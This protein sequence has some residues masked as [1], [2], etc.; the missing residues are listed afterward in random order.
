MRLRVFPVL[1]IVRKSDATTRLSGGGGIV[2]SE[3]VVSGLMRLR[4]FPVLHIVRKS[5][6]TTRLSGGGGIVGAK[7]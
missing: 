5:D 1:Y 2:Q 4:V 3:I 6:A 7:L